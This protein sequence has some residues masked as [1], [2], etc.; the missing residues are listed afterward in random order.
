VEI[1]LER[2]PWFVVGP[3]LGLIVVAVY[4]TVG[5]RLGVLGG[6]G[7]LVERGT[8]AR[9]ALGW[10]AWFVLGIVAYLGWQR[11]AS[12]TAVSVAP[13]AGSAATVR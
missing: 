1:P 9:R 10:E 4:A 12:R 8:G 3:L 2:P 13:A 7:E 11:G 5:E 6:F